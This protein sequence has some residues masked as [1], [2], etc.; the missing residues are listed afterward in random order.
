LN[1]SNCRV[2][3]SVHEPASVNWDKR[4]FQKAVEQ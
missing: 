1:A 4:V 2:G 3:T